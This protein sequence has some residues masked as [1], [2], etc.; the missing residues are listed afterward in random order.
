MLGDFEAFRSLPAWGT[1]QR[2]EVIQMIPARSLMYLNEQWDAEKLT[3][4]PL[5][6]VERGE[7]I[8]KALSPSHSV[9]F[10]AISI[11]STFSKI[12][13]LSYVLLTLH[14]HI[15][16]TWYLSDFTVKISRSFDGN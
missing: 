5:F 10:K 3:P 14:V 9:V 8:K 4:S 16:V 1:I 11:F 2:I 12:C 15:Y 13:K 6:C 7:R